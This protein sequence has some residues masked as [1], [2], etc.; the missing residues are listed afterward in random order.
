VSNRIGRLASTLA[1][2]ALVACEDSE[3]DPD[4]GRDGGNRDATVDM[5]DDAGSDGGNRDATVDT[6]D[7][8]PSLCCPIDETPT[9]DCR[10]T[11]G[12]RQANGMCPAVCDAVPIVEMRFVDE[13]GC[14]AIRLSER[15]CLD[16]TDASTGN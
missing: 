12:S 15:S 9:C 5:A 2:L 14:P 8:V 7:A 4:G 3:N 10:K 11:G 6:G 16:P 1:L 13:N